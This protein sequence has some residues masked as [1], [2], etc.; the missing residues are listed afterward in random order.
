MCKQNFYDST[1]MAPMLLRSY[2]YILLEVL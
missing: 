2:E 1:S